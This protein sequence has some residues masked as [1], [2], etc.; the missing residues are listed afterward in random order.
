M[1]NFHMH[2]PKDFRWGTA[3]AAHQVEGNNTNNNWWA[4]EQGEG[5]ILNNDKSGLACDWWNNAERD[6]DLMAEMGLNAHR[7]SVEWSRIEPQQGFFDDAA[8][9][10][11]REMLLGLRQR[12]IEPMLTLHHF[13]NPLW[14]EEQGGWENHEFVVPLFERF[15]RKTVAVL[16]DVC[17]LWCTV[18]EPNVYAVGAYLGAVT[19]PGKYGRLD[20]TLA[21]VRNLLLGHA[22]A[23]HI[24]HELQP[25]ARVGLAHHMRPFEGLREGHVLDAIIANTQSAIFNDAILKAAIDG[26]WSWLMRRNAPSPRGLKGTLDWIG[27][28]YYSRQRTKFDRTSPATWYGSIH[29]TPDAIM[30]D[31]DYGEIY[32]AG[33]MKMMRKCAKRKLP[34]YITENGI[35][36]ADDDQR[37]AFLVTHLREVWKGVQFCFFIQGYY[38]W[39]FVDNF[40]WSEGWRMKFG[41]FELDHL[42][43]ERIPRKSAELYSAIAKANA[44]TSDIVRQFTPELVPVLFP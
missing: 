30:S 40:E 22:A 1:S 11:Y 21:V 37:P 15:V 14:L 23:Y 43:Q 39:S 42:T 17:D 8:L 24:I 12:G 2:F 32:P 35:P 10:R 7:L 41:L 33:L 29:H 28:N 18:N 44:I 19:P 27:L 36:D 9:G 6:F 3:T 25:Y 31:H 38:H 4:W 26:Q 16:K 13:S 20:L 5:H 34:I